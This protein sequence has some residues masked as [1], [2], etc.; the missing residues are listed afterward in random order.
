[1]PLSIHVLIIG[2]GREGESKQTDRQTHGKKDL[3]VTG[4]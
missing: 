3:Q 1:M 4:S 2:G